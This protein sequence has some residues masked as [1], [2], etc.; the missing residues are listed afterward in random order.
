MSMPSLPHLARVLS[1]VFSCGTT[2]HVP[3]ACGVHVCMSM[4]VHMVYGVYAHM[5]SCAHVCND[6][7]LLSER[8]PSRDDD[9]GMGQAAVGMTPPRNDWR[10][11]STSAAA[12]GLRAPARAT[13]AMSEY[14]PNMDSSCHGGY[15]GYVGYVDGAS[16][17]VLLTPLVNPTR[18][19]VKQII[20][21]H[22]SDVLRVLTL[23]RVCVML[24]LLCWLCWLCGC[25]RLRMTLQ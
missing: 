22:L 18:C 14:L 13:V 17:H 12:V 5:C 24:C 10:A 2:T 7:S 25:V 21:T 19:Q 9:F 3:Y 6:L 23:F 20:H 11:P 16:Y 8:A 15:V 4:R 1:L